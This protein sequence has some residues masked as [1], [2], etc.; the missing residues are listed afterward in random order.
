MIYSLTGTILE[1]SPGETVV[2]CGGVGYLVSMPM[3]AAGVLPAVGESTTVYTVMNVTE[4]DMSL[5]G[6][7]TT[8]E[9]EMFRMLTSVSG[10]GPKA[11]LAILSALPPERIVLAVSASDHK[12]FTAAQGVGPKLAQR[13]VL[14][15]KDKVA[16]GFAT[17]GLDFAE[18]SAASQAP[19]DSGAAQSVAAL[20]SLG[21]THSEATVA[22]AKID[23]GL[24]AAEIIRLA[25]QGIAK[26]GR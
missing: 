26:G 13:L 9:R 14:E 18:V 17:G 22:V 2:E 15:L 20:V 24:P 21:Y 10:V 4:K 5:F 25:L 11:G 19:P 12:A 1:K 8:P 23:P 6:F 7:A 3:S 16:K